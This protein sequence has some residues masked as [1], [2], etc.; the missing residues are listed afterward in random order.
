MRGAGWGGNTARDRDA[1]AER[2][3]RSRISARDPCS[4]SRTCGVS[5]NSNL[6]GSQCVGPRRRPE[7][8]LFSYGSYRSTIYSNSTVRRECA[9]RCVTVVK[10][11]VRE[12]VRGG[13]APDA[14]AIHASAST[15]PRAS[16][17]LLL[18]LAVAHR[19][20]HLLVRLLLPFVRLPVRGRASLARLCNRTLP[21]VHLE[22]VQT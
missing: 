8:L 17:D 19:A 15:S 7:C 3:R 6:V 18:L 2:S 22:L 1:R 9:L 11:F 14:P 16:F 12:P 4:A 20:L 21:F 13:A 5:R 10:S